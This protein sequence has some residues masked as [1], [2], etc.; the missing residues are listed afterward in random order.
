MIPAAGDTR[1]T[2]DDCWNSIGVWSRSR[3]SCPK[4]EQ[5]T[6]CRNC[7][8][9]SNAGRSL[10]ERPMAADYRAEW[11]ARLAAARHTRTSACNA[12][13]LFRVGDEWL[14]LDCRRVREITE[15]RLVHSL[16]HKT[17]TLVRGLV[18]LRGELKVCV[19]IGAL[20]HIDKAQQN[21]QADHEIRERMLHVHEQ[22]YSFVFPVSAVHGIHRY[23][24]NAL[25]PA[26]ATLSK[27][28]QS[29]TSGILGWNN[30]HVGILDHELLF[31]ALNK[32][33]E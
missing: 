19:S 18:N 32:G 10:L 28:R 11:S 13:L 23:P 5:V 17:G 6:H 31:Y 1:A 25:K 7:R 8:H 33:L 20:L 16:P 26:P 9:Y 22:G 21:H 29:F 14:G 24:D 3:P 2:V 27:A 12:A 4:L 15:M 30:Q